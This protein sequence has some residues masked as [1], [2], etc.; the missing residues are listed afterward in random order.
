MSPPLFQN[1]A[2]K[3][4]EKLPHLL[5]PSHTPASLRPWISLL[6]LHFDGKYPV[7]STTH[8]QIRLKRPPYWYQKTYRPNTWTSHSSFLERSYLVESPSPYLSSFLVTISASTTRVLQQLNIA[9]RHELQTAMPPKTKV[10]QQDDGPTPAPVKHGWICCHCGIWYADPWNMCHR[11]SMIQGQWQHGHRK[12][13]DCVPA[14]ER[15]LQ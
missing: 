4:N 8:T 2:Y 9:Q 7:C 6:H 12:C 11:S 14:Y 15:P 10:K 1:A 13:P 3:K 5:R